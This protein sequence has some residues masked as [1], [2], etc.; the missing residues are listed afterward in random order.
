MQEG[1]PFAPQIASS[2]ITGILWL[3]PALPM[4]AAGVIALLKQPRRKPAA[5]L[6]IGS[7]GFSLLLA[8]AAF[9]H[10]ADGLGTG[11]GGA[12]DGELHLDPGGR[13]AG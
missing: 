1:I 9:G 8:L 13:R 2:P 10:V 11:P 6:A 3:I 4:V 5:A 7:L 12:R